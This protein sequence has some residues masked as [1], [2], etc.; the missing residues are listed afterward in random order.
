MEPALVMLGAGRE[1]WSIGRN[2]SCCIGAKR[3]DRMRIWQA[4]HCQVPIV[5]E[6][7]RGKCGRP[8]LTE[9]EDE[10]SR[11]IGGY[12]F[13]WSAGSRHPDCVSASGSESFGKKTHAGRVYGIPEVFSTDHGSD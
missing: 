9:I 2:M 10:K 4:D 3:S 8:W 13:S 12:R 6:D 1:W 7:G 11:A 5:V